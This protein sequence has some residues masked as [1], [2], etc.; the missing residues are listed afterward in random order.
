M[1]KKFL[2]NYS[3]LVWLEGTRQIKE[4]FNH[5][6]KAPIYW[7]GAARLLS[8]LW[9]Y[10]KDTSNGEMQPFHSVDMA[11]EMTKGRD[12]W[13]VICYKSTGEAEIST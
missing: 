7:K 10:K 9:K 6:R 11:L 1:G 8:W 2:G 5:A 13:S 3:S 12:F 4:P